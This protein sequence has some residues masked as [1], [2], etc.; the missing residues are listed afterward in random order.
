ML[1]PIYNSIVMLLGGFR[2]I[3]SI[4]RKRRGSSLM[5]WGTIGCLIR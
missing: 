5:C 4:S 2:Y 3:C 1:V